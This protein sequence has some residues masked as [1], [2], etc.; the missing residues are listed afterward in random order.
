VVPSPSGTGEAV[1]QPQVGRRADERKLSWPVGFGSKIVGIGATVSTAA[2]GGIAMAVNV[3]KV[4]L[5]RSEVEHKPGVLGRVLAPLAAAGVD[6]Q[7][8]MGYRYGDE[9][10]AAIEVCPVSGKKATA[11]AQGV[12]LVASAIPTLL[13]E[14]GDKPGL[15]HAIAQALAE[16]EINIAFLVAQVIGKKFSAVIGFSDEAES[17]KAAGL[18]KKA[19][20]SLRK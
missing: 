2:K 9:G 16:A 7:I 5:W 17:R 20:Q 19:A 18:I 12:G 6:L 10:K 14:G 3:K 13:V 1:R 8:V 15:G 11:A 4:V